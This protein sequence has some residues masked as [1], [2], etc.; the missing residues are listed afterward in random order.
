MVGGNT[1][2]GAQASAYLYDPAAPTGSRWSTIASLNTANA[3]IGVVT[4]SGKIY[5]LGGLICPT[6][7]EVYDPADGAWHVV[8]SPKT[9]RDGAG[10]YAIGTNLYVCGGGWSAY[11]D[12]CESYDTNQGNSGTWKAHP[13]IM[14]DGRRTFGYTNI[15]PVMY[16]ISGYRGTYLQTAERWSFDSYLP[17][18]IK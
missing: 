4:I 1:I 8:T 7:V 5:A 16:A 2:D 6:C 10:V 9:P 13:S 11:H 17:I 3:N 14:I 15:G 12:T 18:T